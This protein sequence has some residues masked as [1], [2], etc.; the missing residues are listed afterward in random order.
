MEIFLQHRAVLINLQLKDNQLLSSHPPR[1][2]FQLLLN[3]PNP[4]IF[5]LLQHKLRT[6]KC[7]F[8]NRLLSLS[9]SNKSRFHPLRH[10]LLNNPHNQTNKL[11]KLK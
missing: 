10:R 6:N 2:K 11:N 5:S 1:S 3:Q 8:N 7:Q 9:Q 4:K